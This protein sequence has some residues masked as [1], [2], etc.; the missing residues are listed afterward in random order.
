MAEIELSVEEAWSGGRY[1]ITLQLPTEQ[2][3]YE[4]DIPVGTTDGHRIRLVGRGASDPM[5][6]SATCIWWCGLPRIPVT[7]SRGGI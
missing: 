2:R 7:G 3:S 5:A 1:R 6:G 4:V